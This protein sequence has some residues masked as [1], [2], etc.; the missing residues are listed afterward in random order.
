MFDNSNEE[1]Q[2]QNDEFS[3]L[4]VERIGL[5][6]YSTSTKKIEIDLL[7]VFYVTVYAHV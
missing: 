2:V 1:A 6:Q 3:S 4:R 5:I 7:L